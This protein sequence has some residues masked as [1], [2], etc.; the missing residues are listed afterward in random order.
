M[1]P[2]PVDDEYQL[3]AI[4]Q[5]GRAGLD[6]LASEQRERSSV[7]SLELVAHRLTAIPQP[8]FRASRIDR[9]APGDSPLLRGSHGVRDSVHLPPPQ[10]ETLHLSVMPCTLCIH[11][12]LQVLTRSVAGSSDR[13]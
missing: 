13:A 8:P 9:E 1:R 7:G 12:R 5:R 4:V 6:D 2:N 10:L 11:H 3:T